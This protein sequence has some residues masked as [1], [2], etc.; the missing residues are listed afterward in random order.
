MLWGETMILWQELQRK[1]AGVHLSEDPDRLNW[2]FDGKRK[3]SAKSFY[4]H[5]KMQQV[6]FPHKKLWK[7]KVPLKI[8]IFLWLVLKNIILTKDN[9]L[10]RGWKGTDKCML[11]GAKESV[12]H[13]FISL[14]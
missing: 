5:L 7:I 3:F 6:I 13:L 4:E 11:C 1:C 2:N 14:W 12:E 8:K 10:R 9:L